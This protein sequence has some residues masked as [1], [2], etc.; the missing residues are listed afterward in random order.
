M[1]TC[2]LT[3][4]NFSPYYKKT[5]TMK[6]IFSLMALSIGLIG[7]SSCSDFLDQNSPSEM[8]N[9]TVY[10]SAYYTGLRVNKIYG[11]MGQ[12]QTYSQ[13]FGITVNLNT[14]IELSNAIGFS[15]NGSVYAAS[16]RGAGH[17]NFTNSWSR[18]ADQWTRMYAIIEDCNDVITGVRNSPL[19]PT[20]GSTREEL[21][22]DLGEAL[23]M[24]AMVYFDLI[25]AWGDIPLK[26][27]VTEADLSNAFLGKTDRDIIMD[28]L[29]TDLDE[30]IDLLPWAGENGYTTEQATKGYAHALLA[31]IAMTRAG[32]AIREQAK[33]GYETA[34]Y[35]DATY[36]TQRPGQEERRALYE[37]ALQ[38]L[39]A[40]ITSGVHQLNPSFEN[41]WYL[42]NQQQ[43][44]MTYK[45]N[46]FEIPMR[47][48][49]S[50]ELGYSVGVRMTGGNTST[51]GYTNN[52]GEVKLTAPFF[53]SYAPNDTRRDVTVATYEIRPRDGRA[54]AEAIEEM[55]TNPFGF[56]VGKWNP[57]WMTSTWLADNLVASG[58]H[59]TGINVVKMRYA[60]VLLFYAECMNEL[61]GSADGTYEGSAG[62]TA[63]QA[64]ALVHNRAF[65][66]AHLP[67]AEAY[68][69]SLPA[70]KD[71]FFNAIVDENAWEFAG[72]GFRK[73]DLIRWNL[74]HDKIVEMK[75]TFIRQL[76][77][78]TYPKT[79]YFNYTDDAQT[80]IDFSTAT[81][82][83]PADE[84]NEADYDAH[85]SW[86]GSNNPED[87][88]ADADDVE[89]LLNDLAS[90]NCGLVG[91][92]G[93][94]DPTGDVGITVKNRYLRP[95]C[96]TTISDAQGSLRNSYDFESVN[97]Q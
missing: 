55:V 22:R 60:N 42:L 14:D 80:R 4:Y 68:I 12:D 84:V 74:L 17:Y 78:G 1:V 30:A 62:L 43:L 86:F 47:Y 61:S 77:D 34:E 56:Y 63:R 93:Y 52:S 94:P 40:V 59:T 53:Y 32:Y 46:I 91:T 28:T 3:P 6:K 48:N 41:E 31:Q 70:D 97:Q 81:F 75:Q 64:L 29:M 76:T 10:N 51:F 20:G 35:T 67:E 90:I 82:Y 18:F 88:D 11:A 58:K 7:I 44:D 66:A 19:Y 26:L 89:E 16:A 15:G 45:E 79:I 33:E 8:N 92:G 23:T 39:T 25:R 24:R 5:K 95:I 69:A 37:R 83:T 87:P 2:L 96:T 27:D 65:D 57:R 9:T 85:E 36:P 38:H 73:Y 71:G 49:V 72:E 54:G 21:G 13:D 50:S